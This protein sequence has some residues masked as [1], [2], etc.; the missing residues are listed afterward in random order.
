M[1]LLWCGNTKATNGHLTDSSDTTI[2][3]VT[4]K[5]NAIWFVI[6]YVVNT[7]YK[8]GLFKPMSMDIKTGKRVRKTREER[9]A[10]I[11]QAATQ[12]FIQ[13]GYAELTL[14]RV[15]KDVDIRL[16]TVQHYFD[17]R[18]ALIAAL[19]DERI[20]HYKNSYAELKTRIGIDSEA[21]ARAIVRFLLDDS[22]SA[23]T[24]GFFTQIW[25]MGFQKADSRAQLSDMYES[26][27]Q[28]LAGIVASLRP[29]LDERECFQRATMMSSM[30][31][32]SLIHLG[33]GLPVDARLEGLRDRIADYLIAL[34]KA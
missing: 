23:D 16:S 13:E 14:R 27:R 21:K 30:I 9:S 34:I 33:H 31:E 17:S 26:H 32:G 25:A 8:E 28:D 7:F 22:L 11:L 4:Y 12:I 19:I 6:I 15:A 5:V 20:Q 29:D 18:E 24:C 3:R 2:G 10:E 1:K